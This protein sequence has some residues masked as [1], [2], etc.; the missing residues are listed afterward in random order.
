MET[1]GIKGRALGFGIF[2]SASLTEEDLP[3]TDLRLELLEDC[4]DSRDAIMV[5]AGTLTVSEL[6]FKLEG[7]DEDCIPIDKQIQLV[8]INV[9]AKCR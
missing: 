3:F 1:G 6:T 4:D 8:E 7:S 9:Q 5:P 2:L